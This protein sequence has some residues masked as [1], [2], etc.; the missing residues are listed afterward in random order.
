MV[1]KTLAP[2]KINIGLKIESKRSD[3]YHNIDTIMQSVSLYDTVIVKVTQNQDIKIV[4]SKNLGCK[5]ESNLAY[6]A[7]TAFF[8][9]TKVKNPGLEIELLKKI[10][11]GAGLAGGS[12]D[13][14]AVIVSLDKIFHTSLDY[15]SL[16]EVGEFVG[17]DVPFCIF[18]GTARARGIGSDLQKIADLPECVILIVKP[19]AQVSTKAAFETFDSIGDK[20]MNKAP[21]RTSIGQLAGYIERQD[22][23][24]VSKNMINDFEFLINDAS[25][26]TLIE[27]IKGFSPL[28]VSMTGSGSAVFGIFTSLNAAENC[29]KELKKEYENCF[30]CKPIKTGVC[31]TEV[32]E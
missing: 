4:C 13:A 27:K 31:I 20:F 22:L 10:P 7:A 21:N 24:T 26:Y 6:K 5:L 15:P 2:A 1:I 12:S 23:Y 30:L 32:I 17:A 19:E 29:Q 16:I 8:D 9:Y 18:G 11:T 14:A 28:G 3:G 25:I